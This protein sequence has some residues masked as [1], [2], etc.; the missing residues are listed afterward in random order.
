M[1][2]KTGCIV[3]VAEF[4]VS[5]GISI[6]VVVTCVKLLSWIARYP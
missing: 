4:I 2:D 3:T 1:R 6:L 5:I